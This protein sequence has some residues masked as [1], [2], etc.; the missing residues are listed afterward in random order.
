MDLTSDA[1]RY[2][3]SQA[4]ER[5]LAD[6]VQYIQADVCDLHEF[7]HEPPDVVK[8]LGICEYLSDEQIVSIASAVA[9]EM[10]A[11]SAIVFNS[12]SKAHHMDRFFRRVFGLHMIHR[13]PQVVAAL[14]AEAGFGDF[15]V[16]RE[17]LGIY[18]VM[19]GRRIAAGP[20]Q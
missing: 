14:M 10:P 4:A 18:H 15:V 17:P 19:V 9:E 7:L 16:H 2:G 1:F 5:G 3:K 20:A 8:M 11:G 12:L 13:G 6:R